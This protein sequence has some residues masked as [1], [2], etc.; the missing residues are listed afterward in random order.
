MSSK[1]LDVKSLE[2]LHYVF[3]K[4]EFLEA[5]EDPE[6]RRLALELRKNLVELFSRLN[7]SR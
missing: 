2:L 6:V 1:V 7:T 4:L 3:E 5:H